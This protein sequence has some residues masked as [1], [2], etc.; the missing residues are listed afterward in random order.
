M[1]YDHINNLLELDFRVILSFAGIRV[2]LGVIDRFIER[3][4]AAR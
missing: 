3:L 1:V 2:G 4:A